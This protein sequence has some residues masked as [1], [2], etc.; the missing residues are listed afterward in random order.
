[1]LVILNGAPSAVSARAREEGLRIQFPAVDTRQRFF[2]RD[3]AAGR[4]GHKGA[5]LGVFTSMYFDVEQ[6]NAVIILMNRGV[7]ARA[8]QA[9]EKLNARLW[10]AH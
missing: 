10:P 2:W 6:K 4:I 5:D 9:M 7:D 8:E 1:L 3:E